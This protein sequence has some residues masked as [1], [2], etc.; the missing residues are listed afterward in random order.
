MVVTR[1]IFC[2]DIREEIGNKHSFMGVYSGQL[3]I[4]RYPCLLQTFAVHVWIA[5]DD[6]SELDQV[7][8]KL[9][10][11][12]DTHVFPID[13]NALAALRE[14]FSQIEPAEKGNDTV[15]KPQLSVNI[16][17]SPLELK[18]DGT[19]TVSVITATGTYRSGCLK[20]VSAEE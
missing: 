18:E 1:A 9:D 10:V 19:I 14:K 12:S 8:I 11:F 20:V 13:E 2:D 5:F 7:S 6:L 17:F 3:V 4:N 16:G 15:G